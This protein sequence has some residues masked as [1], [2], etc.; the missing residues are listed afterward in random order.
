MVN[1]KMRGDGWRRRHYAIKMR[2]KLLLQ[3]AG[4]RA[5]CEV[6]NAIADVIPQRGLSRIERGQRR[7]GLVP[8]FK[9]EWERGERRLCASR[10][11]CP[12][13]SP[14]THATPSPGTG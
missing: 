6:F 4:I 13:R 10:K 3:W 5:E 9:L 7:Q 2:L 12:H 11:R 8:D 14:D 1:A